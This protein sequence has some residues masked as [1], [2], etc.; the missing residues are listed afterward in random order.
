VA[1]FLHFAL[2]C[3][4]V[5]IVRKFGF[6]ERIFGEIL[7]GQKDLQDLVGTGSVGVAG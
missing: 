3:G 6:E 7:L 4:I 1:D 5:P 2:I